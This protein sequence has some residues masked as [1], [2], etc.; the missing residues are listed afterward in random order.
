[1]NSPPLEPASPFFRR[2]MGRSLKPPN[3][4]GMP[5]SL[6]PRHI[7]YLVRGTPVRTET[8]NCRPGDA[9]GER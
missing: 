7:R 6:H 5:L 8:E 3:V 1:M 9:S 4:G 2:H